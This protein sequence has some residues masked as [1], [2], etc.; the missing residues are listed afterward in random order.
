M[1]LLC[2]RLMPAGSR[3]LYPSGPCDLDFE[4]WILG[5]ARCPQRAGSFP[6]WS[7]SSAADWGNPPDPAQIRQSPK[8]SGAVNS[9]L[10]SVINWPIERIK[11]LSPAGQG[12]SRRLPGW[13]GPAGGWGPLRIPG[14]QMD[15]P[16]VGSLKDRRSPVRCGG[17]GGGVAG[18]AGAG[19]LLA[20]AEGVLLA[21]AV[22]APPADG[23]GGLLVPGATAPAAGA[24]LVA[25]LEPPNRTSPPEELW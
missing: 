21:A 16:P 11:N 13:G 15:T 18:T 5:W 23:V 1:R 25:P 14:S 9:A 2:G 8:P 6:T 12:K 17:G 19:G 20:A 22:V 24:G 7:T 4:R 3:P 10:I